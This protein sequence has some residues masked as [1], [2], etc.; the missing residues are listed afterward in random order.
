MDLQRQRRT[1]CAGDF[2]TDDIVILH[3]NGTQFAVVDPRTYPFAQYEFSDEPEAKL[4]WE[5]IDSNEIVMDIGASFGGWTMPALARGAAV[6]SIEPSPVSADLLRRSVAANSWQSRSVIQQAMVWDHTEVPDTFLAAAVN[7]F[8]GRDPIV[9]N[10]DD[11]VDECIFP[12]YGRL[13]R[14][15]MDIEGG[16][17]NAI[18]GAKRTLRKLRPTL[19]I[20][21]HD[22][23]AGT[24]G[25]EAI[26]H[27]VGIREGLLLELNLLGY[28]VRE[29][30]S[31][32]PFF[33]CTPRPL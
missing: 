11:I 2:V 25:V 13:D 9:T 15:K 30:L 24:E 14:I 8:G 16:E 1:S 26:P 28:S 23:P 22:K 27:V 6:Y 19:M 33:V 17:L 29:I 3:S 12:Y 5:D 7:P 32:N 21:V 31:G 18:R 4:F 10:I 20:E